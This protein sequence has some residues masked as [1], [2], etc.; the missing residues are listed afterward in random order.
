MYKITM[1]KRGSSVT[2]ETGIGAFTAHAKA[3]YLRAMTPGCI[4]YVVNMATGNVEGRY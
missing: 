2:V 4:F 1:S 3:R